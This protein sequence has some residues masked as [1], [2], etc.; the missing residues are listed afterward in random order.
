MRNFFV[1]MFDSDDSSIDMHLVAGFLMIL[2]FIAMAIWTVVHGNPFDPRGYGEGAVGVFGGVGAGGW[3]A[4]KQ[5]R[6]QAAASAQAQ[7]QPGAPNAG[8]A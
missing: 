5:R 3:A 6:D 8:N 7:P 2:A 1:A 4:G